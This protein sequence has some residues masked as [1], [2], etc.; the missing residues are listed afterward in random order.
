MRKTK[1]TV[2][3]ETEDVYIN[4]VFAELEDPEKY[5][6]ALIEYELYAQD[7]A[8]TL[9]NI[10]ESGNRTAMIAAL[11]VVNVLLPADY[12]LQ[13]LEAIEKRGYENE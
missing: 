10:A 9:S 8:T 2:H 7:L 1:T 11:K 12:I 4:S 3:D 5:K 6:Q 13:N